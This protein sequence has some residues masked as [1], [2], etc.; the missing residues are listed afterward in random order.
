[1]HCNDTR[2]F[3]NRFVMV[4]PLRPQRACIIPSAAAIAIALARG[5]RAFRKALAGDGMGSACDKNMRFLL[6]EAGRPLATE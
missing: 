4:W 6:A 3:S 2:V 5:Q 1:M